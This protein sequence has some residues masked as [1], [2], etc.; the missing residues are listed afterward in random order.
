MTKKD[1]ET[2]ECKWCGFL[3]AFSGG[4]YGPAIKFDA[5]ADGYYIP[6]PLCQGRIVEM[7]SE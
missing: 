7:E 1:Y 6:C 5:D 3:A 4:P 2:W